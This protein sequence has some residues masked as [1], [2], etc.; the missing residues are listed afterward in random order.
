MCIRVRAAFEYRVVR[1]VEGNLAN[2]KARHVFGIFFFRQ[3]NC[4]GKW[5]TSLV[6]A[7]GIISCRSSRKED[8]AASE[9]EEEKEEQE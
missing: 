6:R 7:S 4:A 1:D 8:G 3:R 5:S 2:E 9:E